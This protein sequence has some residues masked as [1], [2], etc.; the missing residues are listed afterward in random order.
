MSE[1]LTPFSAA[2][3]PCHLG[4]QRSQELRWYLLVCHR[5]PLPLHLRW[6]FQWQFKCCLCV[7][8]GITLQINIA[9]AE[10]LKCVR[11]SPRSLLLGEAYGKPFPTCVT[12]CPS[13][14]EMNNTAHPEINWKNIGYSCNDGTYSLLPGNAPGRPVVSGPQ[15]NTVCWPKWAPVGPPERAC[16]AIPGALFC[17]SKGDGTFETYRGNSCYGNEFIPSCKGFTPDSQRV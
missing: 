11:N 8:P 17:K 15:I 13:V 1:T 6:P 4:V 9:L 3:S 2:V 14:S 12:A 16:R 7:I 5:L 10:M